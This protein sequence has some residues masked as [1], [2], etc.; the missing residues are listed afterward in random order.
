MT[1]I[2]P[3]AGANPGRAARAQEVPVSRAGSALGDLGEVMLNVG[4]GLQQDQLEREMKRAKV[5]LTRDVNTLR[6][7]IEQIGDPDLADEAWNRGVSALRNQYTAPDENGRVRVQQRN[8]EDFGL[9]FDS[10]TNSVGFDIGRRNLGL[11]NAEHEASWLSYSREVVDA[12]ARANPDTRAIMLEEGF[13]MIESD[14]AAGRIDAAEAERR[15]QRVAEDV[16]NTR[17]R[18]MVADDPAGFLAVVQG[19]DFD[20]LS[21]EAIAQYEVQAQN[22]LQAQEKRRADEAERLRRE[23]EA[24]IGDELKDLRSIYSAGRDAADETLLLS[25]DAETHPDYAETMAARSLRNEGHLLAELNLSQ[26][27]A[28]IAGEK[29]RKLEEPWQAERLPLLERWRDTHAKGYR[30]DPVG[31]RQSLGLPVHEIPEFDPS[32]PA[33]FL[34]ALQLRRLDAEAMVK[35]GLTDDLRLFSEEEAATLASMAGVEADPE[36]RLALAGA[37]S[38]ADPVAAAAVS[39]VLDDPVFSHVAGLVGD[40]ATG[41]VARDILRGQRVLAEKTVVLPPERDR[42]GEAF[43]YLKG[44]FAGL[45]AG[46]DVEASVIAAADA[47]YATRMRLTGPVEDI[48]DTVYTQAL[49]EVMGGTGRQNSREARGGLQDYNGAP[50]ILPRGVRTSEVRE[51]FSG[52]ASDLAGRRSLRDPIATRRDVE[53]R[54]PFVPDYL[55]EKEA[56]ERGRSRLQAASRS[57][58]LPTFE[59]ALIHPDDFA[60]ADLHAVAADRYRLWLD[61]E[62]ALDHATGE[63]FEF[64]LTDLLWRTGQ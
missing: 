29:T 43:N 5:D 49:H 46:Q 47:L 52:I 23:R 2:V 41:A 55:D 33:P 63:P 51:T 20:G 11:R 21:G 45:P 53:E 9:M 58:G 19:G 62:Y 54:R 38:Q 56:Q 12:A 15:R 6:L 26:I 22:L 60:A 14:L 24:E 57:G 36:S 50:T 17:A 37:L 39:R 48:D 8:A 7:E 59:G 16:D 34:K 4:L 10:L 13:G 18:R 28:L 64:S 1:L 31:H 44:Y 27:D 61:G 32:D 35:D 25:P 42:K 40:G 3:E 30:T